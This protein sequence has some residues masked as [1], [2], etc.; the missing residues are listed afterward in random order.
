[1]HP[2]HLGVLQGEVAGEL[3]AL[4]EV[5]EELAA[6]GRVMPF[7]RSDGDPPA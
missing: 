7:V 1:M 2:E 5:S 3:L 6:H 4:V